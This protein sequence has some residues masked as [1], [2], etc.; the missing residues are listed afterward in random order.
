MTVDPLRLTAPVLA[1]VT[2]HARRDRPYEAVGLLVAGL[3][4]IVVRSHA[5]ANIATMASARAVVDPAVMRAAVDRY[6]GEGLAVV[7]TYHSHPRGGAGYSSV[8]RMV[9]AIG[10]THLII[11]VD[12]QGRTVLRAWSARADRRSMDPVTIVTADDRAASRR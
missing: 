11:A 9:A 6:A 4:G 8:D 10:P 3:D 2:S 7:G 1:A 12:H 5:M